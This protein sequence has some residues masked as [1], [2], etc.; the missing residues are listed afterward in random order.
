MKPEAQST[1]TDKP[2]DILHMLQFLMEGGQDEG[3]GAEAAAAGTATMRA[4]RATTTS[5]IMPKVKVADARGV[6]RILYK[7][8]KTNKDCRMEE[9]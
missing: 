9:A 5:V 1:Q 7:N 2:W 8:T 3:E 6:I 4:T